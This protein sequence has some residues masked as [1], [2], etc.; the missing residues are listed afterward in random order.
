MS[1]QDAEMK[2]D[3]RTKQWFLRFFVFC[4]GAGVMSVEFGAQRLLEPFFGNSEIVWATLIGIILLSLAGGYAIGGRIAD[5]WPTV[6]GMGLLTA[7][8]GLYVAFLPLASYPILNS[9][10]GGLLNSSA[11]L[12]IAALIG[13]IILF[14]PPVAALGAVSPYSV[15]LTIVNRQSAGTKTGSL[16]FWSTFGSLAGTFI[17]TLYTIPTFGVRETLWLSSALLI[18]LGILTLK[19][20][21]LLVVCLVPLVASQISSPLLK[22]VKGLI[23]EVETP[24]Q[25]AEVYKLNSTET[26]LSVNDSTGIQSLYTPSKLTGL[27]YDA[28]LTLPFMFP[29]KQPVKT[30]LIGMAAGTIP[31]L[32]LRD[33]DPY[34]ANVPI[35]G[36]E[37]DPKLVQLGKRYFH[38]KSTAAKVVNEDGRVYLRTTKSSYNLMI[39]DAYSQ[40][41]YIPFYLTTKQFFQEAAKHL[42]Q[43]GILA[44]NV[45]ATSSK[46]ALLR[47]IE[48][49]LKTVFPH[50]Y[51]A[52]A[53]G[54]Y[55]QLLVGSNKNITLPKN[56]VL[57]GF[58]KKVRSSLA[59]TWR[60]PNPPKG[61][62]LSDNHAPVQE[63]TNQMILSKLGS[64]L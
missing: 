7:A 37:I 20:G 4:T 3:W 41:I 50:V 9:V 42:D 56:S 21:I 32:Y 45:N 57:P 27:Y 36:V 5:K 55:N 18:G 22:P 23:T 24:Y 16:Y 2:P 30:L 8:A 15:R 61:I 13:T 12:V 33:I 17:P 35:T 40:E 19:R 6:H 10:S 25:F 26:A 46:S 54:T 58:L 14:M 60:I 49:T 48:R 52:K 39:V 11:G 44:I 64:K 47:A 59:A 1:V 29:K 31:T 51:I 62:I 63:M 53:P 43:N 38:L 34:R 28:Y